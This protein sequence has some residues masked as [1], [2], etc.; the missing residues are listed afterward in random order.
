MRIVP[1]V[2]DMGLTEPLKLLKVQKGGVELAPKDISDLTMGEFFECDILERI[3]GKP[4]P[5]SQSENGE[6]LTYNE[7]HGSINLIITNAP[8]KV[9]A[10]VYE[11]M[12][13][14]KIQ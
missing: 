6:N 8:Y 13:Q 14:D 9:I 1:K 7:G 12:L 11:I 3:T 4:V 2:N 5:F 10:R